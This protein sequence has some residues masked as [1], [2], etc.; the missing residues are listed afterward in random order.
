MSENGMIRLCG[1]WVQDKNG[2]KYMTGNLSPTTKVLMF[3]NEKKSGANDPDYIL[4]IAQKEA[5]KQNTAQSNQD[6]EQLPF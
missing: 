1:L 2:K 3:R 6:N 5:A 4:F